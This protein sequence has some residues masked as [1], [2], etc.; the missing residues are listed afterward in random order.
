MRPSSTFTLTGRPLSV[1]E[2][3]RSIATSALSDFEP[4]SSFYSVASGH[5]RGAHGLQEVIPNAITHG[6]TDPKVVYTLRWMATER[7]P[8]LPEFNPLYTV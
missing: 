2:I 4:L 8:H 3:V 6:L 1:K 5:P 7:E